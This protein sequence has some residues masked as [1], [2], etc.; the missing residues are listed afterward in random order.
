[1]LD[2]FALVVAYVERNEDVPVAVAQ[3]QTASL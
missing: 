1:M 3:L 2:L